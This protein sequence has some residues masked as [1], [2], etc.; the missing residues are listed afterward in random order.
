MHTVVVQRRARRLALTIAATS[1]FFFT[2]SP[3]AAHADADQVKSAKS[4]TYQLQGDTSRVNRTDADVAV[5]DPDH[6]GSAQKYKRKRSGGDRAVLAY[7]SVGEVEEGRGYMKNGGRRFSTGRTQGWAGNYAAKY[8]DPEWKV[9]VKQR[10][11]EALDKGYDGVYLDRVDTYEGAGRGGRAK[12]EMIDLVE[13]V[14]RTAK[15]KKDNAAVIVQNAEEL[16]EN[17]RYAKAID[18]IAKEDLY[19]GI[20]HDKRRNTDGE[21]AESERHLKKAKAKGKSVMVV[22]Y[23]DDEDGDEAKSRARKNGFVPTTARRELD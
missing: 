20:R 23:L 11:K 2:P 22:E 14:S 7:S 13:E 1:A 4:W 19:H 16:V 6:A 17:E 18:G 3:D 8:W 5:I 21:V 15:S 10:V 9:L 12:Q